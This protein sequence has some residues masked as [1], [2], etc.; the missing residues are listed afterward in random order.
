MCLGMFS[1]MHRFSVLDCAVRCV[2]TVWF[3]SIVCF[4]CAVG[5]V[6]VVCDLRCV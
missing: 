3:V 6:C 2:C 4:E 5:F 1:V